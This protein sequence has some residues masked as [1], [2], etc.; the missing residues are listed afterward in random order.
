MGPTSTSVD[1]AI[2]ELAGVVWRLGRAGD[3]GLDEAMRGAMDPLG[4]LLATGAQLVASA[5]LQLLGDRVELCN[6]PAST[7]SDPATLILEAEQVL[8]SR[9]IEQWPAG[10]SGLIRDVYDLIRE[11][12]L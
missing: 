9:P 1:P 10:T 11:H 2:E 5:S 4:A 12:G 8:A 3:L 6:E 7:S